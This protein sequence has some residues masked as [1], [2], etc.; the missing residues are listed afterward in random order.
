M[1]IGEFDE[2]QHRKPLNKIKA[3]EEQNG[4]KPV[5]ASL[6]QF[7][8]QYMLLEMNNKGIRD[9]DPHTVENLHVTLTLPNLN[10]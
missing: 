8:F 10:F 3:I 2:N 7:S 9:T 1:F 6:V 4:H 5:Y